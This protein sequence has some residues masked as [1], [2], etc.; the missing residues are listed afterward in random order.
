M[1]G[2]ITDEI[3]D[4]LRT[5]IDLVDVVSPYVQ[6]KK[7][8][9]NYFGL[10]PFHSE[11][12]P[13]FSVSPDKQIYYCF[14]CG[15][16]GDAI[17]FI[18]DI[19]QLTF[20]EA[21]KHLADQ[22]NLPLPDLEVS[23]EVKDAE[24]QQIRDSLDLAAKLY[25]HV[26]MNTPFGEV[27]RRYLEKRNI[28]KETVYE[29]Q[30][31]YAP[32]SFQFLLPF[33][34][35][36]G[37]TEEILEKAGLISIKEET[38]RAFDRFRHRLMIPIHDAQGRIIGFGGRLIDGDGPKYLNS[39]ETRLFQK[40]L[41]LFNLH[42]ARSPIRKEQQVV[43]F[44]GSIDVISAWQAGI[45]TV[46]ATLGTALTDHQASLIKRNTQNV[47]LCYDSDNAGQSAS[48]KGLEILREQDCTVKIAQMPIGL[49]P[50]DYIRR[51]GGDLFKE[52]IIA[53]ALPSVAFTLESLK[54]NFNLKDEDARMKYLSQAV[55]VIAD[56][57]KPIEQEHYLQKLSNEFG[58]S[59]EAL[60][61]E[62]R[63]ER[64]KKRRQQERKQKSY[65]KGQGIEA[66]TRSSKHSVTEMSERHLIAH[67]MRSGKVTE[68]A[69]EKIGAEFHTEIYTALAAYIY[70]YY[71][72]G[73]PEDVS[74]FIQS[75]PDDSLKS[76]A[77]ELQM[78]EL[79]DHPSETELNDHL[80]NIKT[81]PILEQIMEKEQQIK[82]LAE[83]DP[84]QAAQISVEI[85]KLK[86]KLK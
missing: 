82:T 33:M 48:V 56:L 81:V 50:D 5:F 86:A 80:K 30:I 59:L 44:E 14:G 60:K 51:H 9:R 47:V 61:E 54:R 22:V 35:K 67:M 6:L 64:K 49:D 79:P 62:C 17:K 70:A 78:I 25:H 75:L 72:Q 39:P 23:E 68:W 63:R 2:K 10:C 3:L 83:S 13:S 34:K 12:T 57:P 84:I 21:V 69:K 18:M 55:G 52:E 15:A 77:S 43:L 19:E 66:K 24:L 7:S 85:M 73:Y 76:K 46:V 8:G 28:M 71:E 37:F 32:D 58:L 20:I 42:R 31:G 26:L 65:K 38:G 4:Q 29:F 74:R 11:K 16:G 53:G 41:H 40:R 27:G 36:R 45:K 1:N